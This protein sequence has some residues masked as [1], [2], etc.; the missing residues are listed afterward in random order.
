[1]NPPWAAPP[2]ADICLCQP[3]SS[4]SKQKG[5]T[6]IDETV[7]DLATHLRK[8]LSPD[9]YRPKV[10]RC[11]S[12]RF[13]VHARRERHPRQLV[14]KGEPVKVVTILVFLCAACSA[15]WRVLPAFLARCLWRSWD[16]IERECLGKPSGS[17]PPVPA[18]TVQRWRV[19]LKQAAR[20]PTQVFALAGNWLRI[21][22]QR[23][24]LEAARWQLLEA[25]GEGFAALATLLHRLAPG[26]RLM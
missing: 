26:V 4:R 11:G 13:H 18:S 1:V 3:Y 10:C 15:S 8:I 17:A 22:A 21:L 25:H 20:V 9:E 12:N 7:V 16:V 6:I 24:G 23:V 2:T 5:G 14:V 19:R